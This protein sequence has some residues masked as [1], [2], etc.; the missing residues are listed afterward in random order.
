MPL[1]FLLNGYFRSGTTLMYRVIKESNPDKLVFY[2]PL[3]NDLFLY[4]GNHK[5]GNIDKVHNI[6]LWDEYLLQGDEFVDRLRKKHPCIDEPFPINSSKVISYLYIF[7]NLQAPIV[8]QLN[9][10]HFV[11]EKLTRHYNIPCVHIIRN[12]L[13]SFLSIINTY[14]QKRSREVVFI[15]DV[16]RKFNLLPLKRAFAIGKGVEFVFK[17]FGKPSKWKD[18][19]FKMRHWNDTLGIFLLN[20]TICNYVAIKQLQKCNGSLLVYEQLVD[21]LSETFVYLE[22]ISGLKFER[23]FANIISKKFIG[24]Y[25]PSLVKKT[26]NKLREYQIEREWD[27]VIEHSGYS[28]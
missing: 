10:I 18:I 19:P 12:P 15:A 20:W 8:L 4:L 11:L 17:Y 23:K 1:V 28:F 16:L 26:K 21:N 14:R 27:Y 9:R 5:I 25:N 13:D 24:Q 22:K 7:H 6:C 3:H 2:E